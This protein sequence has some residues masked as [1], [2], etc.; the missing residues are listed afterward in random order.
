MT[1]FQIGAASV[2]R[3]EESSGLGFQAKILLPNWHTGAVAQHRDWLVPGH[4]NVEKQR[5][6][7]SVHSWLIRT[8]HHN[9]LVDTCG[10]DDKDRPD[11]P[12]FHQKKTGFLGKL[13]LLF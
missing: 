13:A 6:V 11:F 1:Q 9:I 7:L 2:T 5:F 12:A 8:R 10:G 3:I 4:F